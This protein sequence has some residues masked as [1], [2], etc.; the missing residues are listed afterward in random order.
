MSGDE[1]IVMPAPEEID[2]AVDHIVEEGL[3]KGTAAGQKRRT[4]RLWVLGGAAVIALAILVGIPLFR[5]DAVPPASSA[6]DSGNPLKHEKLDAK[7]VSF[8]TFG[9]MEEYADVIVRVTREDQET[10][11]IS[12]SGE[13]IVSGFTFSQVRIE[14]IYKDRTGTL[15]SGASVRVLENEFF[16]E[17]TNTVFHVAGYSMMKAGAPYLLFLKRNTAA[18]GK[19]YYVAAGVHFGTV[20]LS[21]DGR[22]VRDYDESTFRPFWDEAEKKYTAD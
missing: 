3:G 22:T 11:V 21:E 6:S 18:D 4:A 16:D 10:T 17:K 8:Q 19:E 12:R 14:K 20:S 2:R 1:K 13:N 15:Q 5:K 7:I 9:E